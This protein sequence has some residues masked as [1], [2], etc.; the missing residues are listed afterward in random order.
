[1]DCCTQQIVLR[2][3]CETSTFFITCCGQ[4]VTRDETQESSGNP[5]CAR[6][7]NEPI[8][9]RNMRKALGG[10]TVAVACRCECRTPMVQLDFSKSHETSGSCVC[11]SQHHFIKHARSV[12]SVRG[13]LQSCG[14]S[15]LNLF[16]SPGRSSKRAKSTRNATTGPQQLKI[17]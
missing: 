13:L 16:A 10:G 11:R 8:H 6:Y 15:L 17:L 5:C 1:M 4:Y 7:R 14:C 9:T 2:V 3:L 12:I